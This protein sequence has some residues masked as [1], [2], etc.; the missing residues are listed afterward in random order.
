MYCPRVLEGRSS[1]NTA[2]KAMCIDLT[3]TSYSSKK[4]EF[5]SNLLSV[6]A[7]DGKIYTSRHISRV[8]L[9]QM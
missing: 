2:K 4:N 8:P 5:A 6:A 7:Q 3:H 9:D 1:K